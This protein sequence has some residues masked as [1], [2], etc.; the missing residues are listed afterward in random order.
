MYEILSVEEKDNM[1]ITVFRASKGAL[2]TMREPH[3][4]PEEQQEINENFL[5]AAA[6]ICYP[7]VDLSKV[8]KIAMICD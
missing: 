7:D 6:A 3:H 5:M 1:T 8:K 2:V 4:T